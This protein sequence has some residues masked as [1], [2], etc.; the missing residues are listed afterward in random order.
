MNV[1]E[2]EHAP[3]KDLRILFRTNVAGLAAEQ[4]FIDRH[5]EREAFEH[6]FHAHGARIEE[7]QQC[8]PVDVVAPRRNIISYYGLGG[9]GK[10]TLS[11]HLQSWVSGEDSEPNWPP[12]EGGGSRVITARLDLSRD[13]G[14]DFE[15]MLI[16]LRVAAGQLRQNMTAFDIAFSRYWEYAHP[17]E[18]FSD[19]L[20][21]NSSLRRLSNALKLPEQ[22]AKS[23]EEVAVYLGQPIP[24]LSV[25]TL[26]GKALIT[27]LR[28]RSQRKRALNGCPRLPDLLEAGV[29]PEA[30]GYYPY[31]LAWDLHRLQQSQPVRIVVFIDTF[32]DV[33]TR[34]NRHLERYLQ[35][36]MWLM[37]N[38]FFV[39]TGRNRLE[40]ADIDLVG[41]LDWVG[42]VSWP[43]LAVGATEDPR[44]HLVGAL[45]EHDSDLFLRDRLRRNGVPLIGTEVRECIVSKAQG[46]PLHLD[47]CVMRFVQMY[48]AEAVITPAEF[49]VGF[50]GL[51]ARIF[52]DLGE[53]ERSVLRAVSLFDAFDVPLATATAGAAT[54]SAAIRLIDRPFVKIGEWD[55]WRYHLDELIRGHIVDADHGLDDSWNEADWRAAAQRALSHM[56]RLTTNTDGIRDRRLLINCLN[57]GL[58]LAHDFDL[59]LGW[60]TDAAYQF[61]ADHVWEPTLAPRIPDVDTPDVLLRTGAAALAMTLV[62]IRARQKQH[63]QR[64]ADQLKR[65][66]DSGLLAVDARDL[67]AYFYAEC[68]RDLGHRDESERGMQELVGPG[69]RMADTAARG[70]SHLQRR[71]GQFRDL[72]ATLSTQDRSATW[73]RVTGDLW[74]TQARFAEAESAYQAARDVAQAEG[75]VGEAALC[76]ACRAFAVG[77]A[78]PHRAREVVES[79]R[80]LLQ[81]VT[82]TWADLQVRNA[83]LLLTAG[84]D[85]GHGSRCD[86]VAAAAE[87]NGLSSIGAY[88]ELARGLHAAVLGDAHGL[89]VA[90]ANLLNYVHGAEFSYL[91]EII[92]FWRG[93]SGALESSGHP[94]DWVDGVAATA[95]RWHDVVRLRVAGLT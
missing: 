47:L 36:L 91:V 33:G 84:G 75:S 95:E 94:A 29:D 32:E 9:I 50:P 86:D 88:T 76:E 16:I 30:L 4:I 26:T 80:E 1:A 62:A 55:P 24:G 46:L 19:Y 15:T 53:A 87:A 41:E 14:L 58:R 42:P 70:L 54:E 67:A 44:Q 2:I 57:Q 12:F 73:L 35:R 79:A 13:V 59:E 49:D 20:K 92:D 63:R 40:W 68:M 90:R 52:R 8:N 60:L 77:F 18:S 28:S 78:E 65:C 81:A 10:T 21:R 85:S 3:K 89:D 17:N 27:Q 64:T 48:H 43:G 93:T 69:R 7:A 25:L 11:Q 56:G 71:I 51:V 5:G 61:I 38:V 74:W 6:A 39:V 66:L 72:Q 45:S 31:L 37:P 23:L 22:L 34:S 83:E 82:I